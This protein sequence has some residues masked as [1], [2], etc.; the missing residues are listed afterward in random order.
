MDL[1]QLK[2]LV[3]GQLKGLAKAIYKPGEFVSVDGDRAVFALE[4][5][6]A[7]ERA[8]KSRAEVEQMLAEHFGRPVSLVLIERSDAPRYGGS[9]PPAGDGSSR[10][11]ATVRRPG[12]PPPSADDLDDADDAEDPLTI[13]I[14]ELDNADDVAQTGLDRLTRAFPGATLVQLEEEP[15]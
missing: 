3:V 1:D 2:E 13:D 4:N 5:A 12:S 15:T 9:A 8:E 10:G 6:P 11:P 7:R 14:S